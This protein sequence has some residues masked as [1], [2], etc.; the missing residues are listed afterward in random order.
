MG[1]VL[2]LLTEQSLMIPHHGGLVCVLGH[3]LR[4]ALHMIIENKRWTEEKSK[5][6]KNEEKNK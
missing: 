1:W 2:W 6:E 4:D 3:D 5:E